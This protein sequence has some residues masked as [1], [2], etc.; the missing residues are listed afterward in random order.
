MSVSLL[1]GQ[2]VIMPL[3][4]RSLLTLEEAGFTDG[5]TALRDLDKDHVEHLIAS[6]LNDVPPIVVAH[7]TRGYAV[8]DG[9]HR[10]EAAKELEMPTIS[11]KVQSFQSENDVIDAAFQANIKH[12]LP[13][14]KEMRNQ[15]V[16]WLYLTFDLTQDEIAAKVS[17][18]RS[19]VSRILKKLEAEGRV[20]E[21]TSYG[22]GQ[23]YGPKMIAETKGLAETI[24]DF[25]HRESVMFGSNTGKRSEE[26]RARAL[27]ALA[28]DK[29]TANMYDSLS[30]SFAQAAQLLREQGA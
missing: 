13:L 20:K 3:E 24:K 23:S 9:Y 4:V 10:W 25:F 29:G 28:E 30:R 22:D 21:A 27:V 15:Y 6:S 1:S 19:T 5:N 11:A 14:G 18:N 2:D 26:K 8:V 7:T 12:G 17:L 16:Q